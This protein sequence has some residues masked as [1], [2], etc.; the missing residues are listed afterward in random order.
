[1]TGS[2]EA[3]TLNNIGAVWSDLGEKRQALDYYEQ[4][5]P[6]RRAVGDRRGEG[7]SC[8]N[9]ARLF[10]ALGELDK[11]I[12]YAERSATLLVQIDD[13]NASNARA[14]LERLRRKRDGQPEA[15]STLP[16]ETIQSLARNTVAVKTQ[17]LD[18]LDGWRGQLQ[19]IRTEFV[20]KGGDWNI[21]VAFIDALLAVL[22]DQPASVPHDNPYHAV[23]V[24]VVEATTRQ[25]QSK[26]SAKEIEEG[27]QSI[28]IS[29]NIQG[30]IVNIAG[31]VTFSRDIKIEV[32]T[33]QENDPK[34][35]E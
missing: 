25:S 6:L 21:E 31:Q 34:V 12:D 30:G 28:L 27:P 15:P 11:A 2:G 33:A 5:L 32:N 7:Y 4:V 19:Q 14:N 3:T 16:A 24:Q 10:E 35:S 20:S 9:M 1:V 13:V 18:K 8:N 29:G 23:L 22:S 26:E 17:V